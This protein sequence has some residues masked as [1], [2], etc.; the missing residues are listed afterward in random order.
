MQAR[1]FDVKNIAR[2][3]IFLALALIVTLVENLLPP[4]VPMLP[5]AKI[6]LTNIVLLA[7]FVMLGTWQGFVVLAL[8]CLFAAIFAGNFGMLMY[9]VPAALVSYVVMILLFKTKLFSVTG[10]S[11]TGAIIH[12]TMQIVVA[13][14]IIGKSV[15]AY[16][17]YMMLAGAVA[18]IVTGL[19]CW[20][21]IKYMPLKVIFGEGEKGVKAEE[22]SAQNTHDHA[23]DTAATADENDTK[24]DK[25]NMVEQ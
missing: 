23:F 16:L 7:C 4:I 8:K 10:I 6:G 24:V 14:F 12:N 17:P 13:S 18:G 1:K 19:V 5:Y 25:E 3:G 21:V 22:I 9:S 2:M 20:F 11:V 15:F